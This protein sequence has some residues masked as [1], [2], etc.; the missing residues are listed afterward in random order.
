LSSTRWAATNLITSRVVTSLV[1]FCVQVKN[2]FKSN[3]AASR[4]ATFQIT[5]T[6]DIALLITSQGS[7]SA[8]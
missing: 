6:P 5:I 7:L 2:T 3:A 4:L 1:S 8:T